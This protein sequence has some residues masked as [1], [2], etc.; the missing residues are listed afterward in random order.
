MRKNRII[1]IIFAV[2]VLA[3]SIAYRSRL[4]AV[5]LIAAAAYPVL[6]AVFALIACKTAQAGFV[7]KHEVCQKDTEFEL[8]MFVRS[9]F[10]FPLAPIELQCFLPDK[11]TGLFSQKRIYAAVPPFGKCRISTAARHLYRGSYRAEITKIAV[12]DPLRIIYISEKVNAEE[13]LIILPRRIDM[14]ELSEKARGDSSPDPNPLFKG[15]RDDF[16]HV[17]EYMSGDMMQLVHWKLT[18]KLDDLMIKQYDEATER[19]TAIVCDYSFEGASTEAAMRQA[20]AVIEAALAFTLSAVKSGSGALVLFS[21]IN[22]E[23]QSVIR[24]MPDFERLYEQMTV[25]PAQTEAVDITLLMKT[26]PGIG[27]SSVIIITCRL[28]EEVINSAQLTA[29]ATRSNVALV[30]LSLGASSPLEEKAKKQK[31]LFLNLKGGVKS[32]S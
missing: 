32:E 28:T 2:G 18:A 5:L 16:S 8:W 14:G 13:T 6:A 30:W 22:C 27:A 26:V 15:E 7:N 21:A 17:R 24:D 20:D 1:Y 11:D 29:G 4:S 31:F 10:I 9:R 23:I 19:R 12:C 3:F 25:L